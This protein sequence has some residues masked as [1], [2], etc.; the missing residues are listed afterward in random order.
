MKPSGRNLIVLSGV[1]FLLLWVEACAAHIGGG[2]YRVWMWLPVIFLPVAA[3]AS[4]LTISS[5]QKF[6]RYFKMIC[7]LAVVLGFAGFLFHGDSFLDQ[8]HKASEIKE[9][10]SFFSFPPVLAPLAISLMGVLGW[11]GTQE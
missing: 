10:L 6:K 8:L 7:F 4:G 2:L 5:P 3:F 9:I 11:M 1:G